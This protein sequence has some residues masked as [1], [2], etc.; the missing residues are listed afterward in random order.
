MKM[1]RILKIWFFILF[2]NSFLTAETLNDAISESQKFNYKKSLEILKTLPQN[3]SVKRHLGWAYLK[4]GDYA[5]ASETFLSLQQKDYEILFGLGFSYFLQKNYKKSDSYLEKCLNINKHCAAA[6]YLCGEIRRL[7]NSNTKSIEF[8]KNALKKDYNFVEARHKLAQVYYNLKRYDESFNEYS[9]ILNIDSKLE[10]AQERKE[11]LLTL[12][13]KKPEEVSP[14]ERIYKGTVVEPAPMQEQIP[15][16]RIGVL[17]DVKEIG[18]WSED[19]I[20]IFKN[21]ELAFTSNPK[22]IIV[23][24]TSS[25]IFTDNDITIKPKSENST[26]IVHNVKYASGFAWAGISDREYRGFFEL[27]Y[28]NGEFI[29]IN[30]VNIE[31]YLYSVLPSEMISWWPAEALK[32]QAVIARSEALYKKKFSEGHKKNGFDL[33]ATQHC[34]VYKGVKQETKSSIKAVNA[35]RGEVLEYEGKLAHTLYS[36]NCSGCTQ[37]SEEL[38]GWVHVPYLKGVIDAD[39]SVHSLPDNLEQLTEWLKHP[40]DIFCAPSKYTYYA[41]S[42]WIR[43]IGQDELKEWI[44][45]RY[46]IGGIKKIIPKKRVKSWHIRCLRMEGTDGSVEIE[47]ENLIRSIVSGYLRSTN[48]LVEGYG[49]FSGLPKYFVFWG[50]GWGHAVGLCQSGAAGMAEKGFKYKD[51]LK[52][53]YKDTYIKKMGY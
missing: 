7:K 47:K 25:S 44:N 30:I 33:C 16:L 51:I 53:Y 35:T 6:E 26:I 2:L 52:K 22:E 39:P 34:Q 32:S 5:K 38:K 4:T 11:E 43:I 46:K 14:P 37:S 8:Y 50:A 15:L 1:I 40:P 36:S 10:E 24:S 27:R 31:E 17:E 48:F 19:G 3:S 42:R 49:E 18:M 12:I 13:S 21:D 29:L 9:R 20:K 45:R 28:K 23:I 41:E